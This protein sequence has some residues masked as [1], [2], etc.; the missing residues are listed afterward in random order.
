MGCCIIYFVVQ[1]PLPSEMT[2][3]V[4]ENLLPKT[5]TPQDGKEYMIPVL[6]ISYGD[7]NEDSFS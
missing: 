7:H 4:T 3:Q 1:Q 6:R 5:K 2:I